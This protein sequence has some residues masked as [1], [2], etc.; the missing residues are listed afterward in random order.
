MR[1]EE[2]VRYGSREAV[3]QNLKDAGCT[4]EMIER[5][6]THLEEEDMG[7]LWKLLEQHRS[8]LLSIVHE[9]E[10]Q[11]S[12]LDYFVYQIKRNKARKK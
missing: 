1:L 12:C 2:T 9:R 10:K 11:I 8:C 4:K 7:E 3:I 5:I 6:M